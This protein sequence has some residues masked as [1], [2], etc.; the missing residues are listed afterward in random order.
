MTKGTSHSTFGVGFNDNFKY[1][2]LKKYVIEILEGKIK[3]GATSTP[4]K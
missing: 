4:T 2:D 3:P 1:D